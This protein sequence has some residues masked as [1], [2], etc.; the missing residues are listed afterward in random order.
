MPF[1]ADSQLTL[2]DNGFYGDTREKR[3]LHYVLENATPNKPDSVIKT[4]DE[5]G[6]TKKE[7]CMFIGDEKG[8]IIDDAIRENTPEIALELGTYY[9]YSAIRFGHLMSRLAYGAKYY[10]FESNAMF[11]RIATELINF[12]G[13]SHVIE[14]V[15]GTFDQTLEKFL[16]LHSEIKSIDFV[17]IDHIKNRYLSDIKLMEKNKLI[18]I[19]T[20][21]VADNIIFPGAPDY[22]QYVSTSSHY[23]TVLYN[24]NL[25]YSCDVKDAIAISIHQ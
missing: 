16:T 2:L 21:V 18:K 4:M 23:H 3:I 14:I 17:L 7:F 5:F 8:A 1:S 22:Y 11:A 15:Q 10:T 13:L 6:Y 20:V 9:G 25:E 12:A 24:T 19:D